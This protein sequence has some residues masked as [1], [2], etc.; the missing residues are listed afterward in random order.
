MLYIIY[1]IRIACHITDPQLEAP[2][3]FIDIKVPGYLAPLIMLMYALTSQLLRYTRMR[4][5]RSSDLEFRVISPQF[6][7][8]IRRRGVLVTFSP[9]PRPPSVM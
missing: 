3:L 8:K 1:L 5:H 6:P 4:H 7:R 2:Y 9:S